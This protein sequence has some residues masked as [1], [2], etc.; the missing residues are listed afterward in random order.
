MLI[1]ACNPM[2]CPI[3]VFRYEGR[4]LAKLVAGFTDPS[5]ATKYNCSG[6]FD[7]YLHNNTTPPGR[8]DCAFLLIDYSAAGTDAEIQALPTAKS[9]K[10]SA[11]GWDDRDALGFFRSAWGVE[12]E[13][14]TGKHA[15]LAFK[16]AN[17]LPNHNDLDGGTF[18]F[19]AGG[20]RWGM[21]MGSDT[22]SLKNYFSQNLKYRYGYYRKS[23][24]GH[25]TLTF[26]NDGLDNSN[27]GAC[28]QEPGANGIT[29]ITLFAG[30]DTHKDDGTTAGRSSPAYSIVDLTAAYTP[31]NSSRVERGFAFT[32]HHAHLLIVDEFE[33]PAGSTLRNATWTM[34]TMAAIRLLTA[35]T[36]GGGGGGT[37]ELSLGGVR[38][39][40]TVL[41][42]PGAVF[43][44]AAVDLQPPQK[45]SVGVSKLQVHVNLTASAA[46]EAGTA[47]AP[48]GR[49]VVGLSLSAAAAAVTPNALAQWKVAGP[50]AG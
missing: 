9:F 15:Y 38:L 10:L 42:P 12:S 3:H 44:A 46:A 23:T 25:N 28:D 19:E 8:M 36:S 13:G 18:V 14:A 43:S 40:A 34:H 26:D 30:S 48:V 5:G 32:E 16:A 11:Y 33:F 2:L 39:H 41:E 21:D 24:A 27:R 35:G 49:I 17:G 4:R 45:P 47:A 31:Q 37:A 7:S 50:F 20:Q 1:D 6:I 22:Y 29:A